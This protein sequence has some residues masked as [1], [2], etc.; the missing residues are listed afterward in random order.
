[1]VLV[2]RPLQCACSQKQLSSEHGCSCR[3]E[4]PLLPLFVLCFIDKR[5]FAI[6]PL[7]A[8]PENPPHA[9]PRAASL[10]LKTLRCK[11]YCQPSDA[12]PRP[13]PV[14]KARTL[15]KPTP[16]IPREY[17]TRDRLPRK[18]SLPAQLSNRHFLTHSLTA[19]ACSDAAVQHWLLASNLQGVSLNSPHAP[20]C[21]LFSVQRL[22]YKLGKTGQRNLDIYTYAFLRRISVISERL[23]ERH[24]PRSDTSHDI[25]AWGKLLRPSQMH[26]SN[27]FRKAEVLK[28]CCASVNI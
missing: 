26:T 18:F 15:I 10:L 4:L 24:G 13:L 14:T 2:V 16:S 8:P 5:T 1:M 23:A 9:G 25:S 21:L 3:P 6:P 19:M 20:S 28:L 17:S 27:M 22:G 11:T 7:P 12:G